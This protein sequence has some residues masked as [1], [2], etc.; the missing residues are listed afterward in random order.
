MHNHHR[1][2]FWPAVLILVGLVALLANAGV[3]SSDRLSL[4]FDLWPLILVVIGL[5]LIARRGLQGAAGEV[6]GVLIVLIAI[7]GALV[8]V[9]LAPN[10]NGSGSMSATA[11]V[12]SLEHAS[13]EIDVGAATV[14]VQGGAPDGVLYQASIDYS[15]PKPQVS[16]DTSSGRLRISQG[17]TS[18]GVFRSNRFTLRLLIDSSLPWT[19]ATNS[20][21]STDTYNLADVHVGSIDVNT[22]ASREDI[23]LGRPSGVVPISVNG[24]ALTVNLH[25]PAGIA[26]SV[27][28]SG[29]AVSLDADGEQHRSI[30]SQS[31]QSSGFD[32]ATDAYRVE[33]NGGACTVTID[34]TA[35]SA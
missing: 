31:W 5:E 18:F 4:L 24:G 19:I 10:P 33:V 34:T 6:A 22:G 1:G 2:L 32:G 9:A 11:P 30:G 16:L 12:G 27:R 25:R 8:Y 17:N 14:T 23:T 7:G 13:F 28:V 29:G 3:I 20:G 35:S 26:A 21:A 15:G